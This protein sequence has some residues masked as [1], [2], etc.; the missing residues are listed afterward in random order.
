MRSERTSIRPTILLVG[1]GRRPRLFDTEG[2]G[3]DGS[4]RMGAFRGRTCRRLFAAGAVVVL[5]AA[6]GAPRTGR[7]EPQPPA[8]GAAGGPFADVAGGDPVYPVVTYVAR[9]LGVQNV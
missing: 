2:H 8:G 7:A 4:T 5:L 9:E 6:V 1:P 3:L